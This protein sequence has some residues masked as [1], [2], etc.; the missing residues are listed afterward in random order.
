MK[1]TILTTSVLMAAAAL[2]GTASATY[3][4]DTGTP[5]SGVM[6]MSLDSGDYYAAEFSLASG[7]TV[8][9]IQA[10]MTNAFFAD[11][12]GDTFTL[13]IYSGNNFLNNRNA[14]AVF[15]TQGTYESDGWNGASGLSWTA[16]TGGNYWA[17]VEINPPG[18]TA[19][20]LALPSPTSGGTVAA[21]DFAFNDGS[22]NGY[23]DAGALPFGIQVAATTPV[24][25]P[26]SLWLFAC[27]A[28]GLGFGAR[29]KVDRATA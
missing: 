11:S 17:A 24:P 3:V 6:A 5:T 22:G 12:P 13:A 15:S 1:N 21:Q 19:A 25:L 26:P 23:S 8:T 20:N 29:R 14:A 18:D 27:G 28:L 16:S 10:Y 9:S 4:L 7:S 2:P